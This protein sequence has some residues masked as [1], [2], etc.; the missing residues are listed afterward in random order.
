MAE[1]T[2]E[3]EWLRQFLNEIG[4]AS[5]MSVPCV[6]FG[7]NASAL[8]LAK[9]ENISDRSKHIRTSYHVC[10]E[11]ELKQSVK[12]EFVSSSNNVAD[13]LTKNLYALKTSQ[14][15]KMLGLN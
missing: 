13:I 6:I 15:V 14:F 8:K 12:F 11:L 3:T 7:D 1:A 5:L 2:R 9:T 10:K 4:Q